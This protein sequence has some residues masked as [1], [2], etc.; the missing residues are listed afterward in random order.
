MDKMKIVWI[1]SLSNQ[2]IRSRLLTRTS[3]LEPFFMKIVKRKFERGIDTAIWNTNAINVIKDIPQ[4]ELHIVSPVRNLAIKRQDFSID[5]IYY[6]F[7][8][9]ENSALYKKVIRFLF[10]RF[11]TEFKENRKNIC[12]VIEE[13]KPDLVHIIGA[14]NPQYSLALLD[15]PKTIPTLLQLQALLASI[16]DKVVGE[17]KKVFQYK[18]EFEKQLIK[19]A[20]YI[21]TCAPSFIEYIRKEIKAEAILVNTTLA[22]AQKIDLTETSKEYDFVHFAA[23]LGPSKATDIAIEAFGLAYKKHPEIKLDIIGGITDAFKEQLDKRISKLGIQ[24]AITF[25]GRLATHDDVIRQIRKSR[26][27]LLPLKVS[28]VPNTLH[29]AMA[30]GLPLVTTVTPGT[31]GLN[32]KRKS[33]LISPAGDF[34]DIAKNMVRLLEDEELGEELRQNAALTEHEAENNTVIIKHWVDVYEAICR[35]KKDGVTIPNEFLL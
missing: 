10:T 17:Q 31:P 15:L 34:E 19:R 35:N 30:N 28:L 33:V 3:V 23:T 20:D 2:E 14:E 13:I 8:R 26:F 27:A 25:E 12:K 11:S 1:C 24:N 21:G 22:M 7:L 29:E 9:D 16:V 4:V 6:H 32:T 5:G 18:A